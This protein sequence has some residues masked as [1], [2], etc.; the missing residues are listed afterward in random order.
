LWLFLLIVEVFHFSIDDT[1]PL[2][3]EFQDDL[4]PRQML[5]HFLLDDERFMV[6]RGLLIE[7]LAHFP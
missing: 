4:V 1:C 5:K 7:H 2:L 6:I 3:D